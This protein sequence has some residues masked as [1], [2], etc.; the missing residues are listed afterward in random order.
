MDL[1]SYCL[2]FYSLHPFWRDRREA[3]TRIAIVCIEYPILPFDWR[4]SISGGNLYYYRQTDR[5]PTWEHP[6]DTVL[7]FMLE[8]LPTL[9]GSHEISS[10]ISSK[11][12]EVLTRDIYWLQEATAAI[13][14]QYRACQTSDSF[15]SCPSSPLTATT[16]EER[17]KNIHEEFKREPR[18]EDL[19]DIVCDEL[20]VT[21]KNVELRSALH[22]P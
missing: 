5:V 1:E 19:H 2:R 3:L 11:L 6:I 4:C 17:S 9:S 13:L 15:F 10:S 14:Q 21:F 8:T 22:P 20:D 12:G 7:T 18:S 16:P